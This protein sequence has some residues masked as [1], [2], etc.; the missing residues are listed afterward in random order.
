MLIGEPADKK[1]VA[2]FLSTMAS[3][4]SLGSLKPQPETTQ[5]LDLD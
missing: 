2:I 3:S 4:R 1:T 5:V